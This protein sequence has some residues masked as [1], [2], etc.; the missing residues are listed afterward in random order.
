[1]PR[2][3]VIEDDSAMAQTLARLLR[4]TGYAAD[5]VSTVAAALAE[6]AA[7]APDAVVMDVALDTDAAPLHAALA[8]RGTPVLLLSGV[9]AERLPEIARQRGWSYLAKPAEP[10]A[11]V[12][13]VG[14]LLGR[15]SRVSSP[16][17]SRTPLK[18]TAQLVSETIIDAIALAILGAVLLVVRP[19]SE[20]MQGGCIVGLLLL[21]GVR[22][23]DLAAVAKGLPTRG[24]PGAV[25]LGLLGAAAARIGG[26]A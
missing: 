2:I 25:V 5:S 21:A 1:M 9:E 23:A 22:V 12:E 11:L 14:R 20:W 15:P 24:G 19:T 16:D 3:L 18:S 26:A 6:I 8:R 10:D 4:E 17:L 13:A 7:E